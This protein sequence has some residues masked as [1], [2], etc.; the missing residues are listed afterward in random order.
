MLSIPTAQ[1]V[2]ADLG[3]QPGLVLLSMVELG[4]FANGLLSELGYAEATPLWFYILL[5]A[6]LRASGRHLGALGSQIVAETLV[7]LLVMD[8]KSVWHVG[9]GAERLWHP[10]EAAL[11]GQ[12][13]DTFEKF[14]RFAG[15]M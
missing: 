8:G 13:I 5:E 3:M 14:L 9:S 4:R 15:V 6:E 11:M 1:Q 2:L 7:G 12:P 10:R